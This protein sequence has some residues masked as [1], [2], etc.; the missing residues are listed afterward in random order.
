MRK[1]VIDLYW[2]QSL[3]LVYNLTLVWGLAKWKAK[4]ED[5]KET[6]GSSSTQYS[7]LSPSMALE[8]FCTAWRKILYPE[9]WR[10]IGRNVFWRFQECH[11]K[12][13]LKDTWCGIPQ[14]VREWMQRDRA[15]WSVVDT[16]GVVLER[17]RDTAPYIITD[18]Q[19]KKWEQQKRPL[20]EADWRKGWMTV[21]GA[22]V[23]F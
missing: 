12:H 21:G 16:R 14:K 17:Q 1:K 3:K 22:V 23:W 9:R 15:P 4:T 13:W 7:F 19:L 18:K 2:C 10:R 5:H 20:W 11:R 8:M 6:W